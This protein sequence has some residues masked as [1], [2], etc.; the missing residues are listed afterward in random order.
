MKNLT[1]LQLYSITCTAIIVG[2]FLMSMTANDKHAKFDEITIKRIN[3]IGE[4]GSLRMILSNETRQHPGRINGKDLPK[5]ER[6]AGTLYFNYD[7]DECG[8]LLYGNMNTDSVTTSVFSFT[9]DQY[10]QDQV[11]QLINSE[12]VENGKATIERGLS[13]GEY[14]VGS[15]LGHIIEKVAALEKISDETERNRKIA[16]YMQENGGKNRMFLGRNSNNNTG[17]FIKG[18]DGKTKMKIYVDPKGDPQI[19]VIDSNGKMTNI[20]EK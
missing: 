14:P 19:E 7:G 20:L 9:M 3:L 8:G 12:Y 16:D 10:K 2:I 11:I 5:R 1:F 13:I 6:G 17:L 4:D 18:P 15:N